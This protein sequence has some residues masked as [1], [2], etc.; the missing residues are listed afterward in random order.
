MTLLAAATA[1]AP[2]TRIVVV[3]KASVVRHAA[4]FRTN[5]MRTNGMREGQLWVEAVDL[6][7]PQ[8]AAGN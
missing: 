6:S 8:A 4:P 1:A 3:V 7:D 2:I 5:G